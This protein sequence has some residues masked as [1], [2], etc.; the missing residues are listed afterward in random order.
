MPGLYLHEKVD[1]IYTRIQ[2]LYIQKLKTH[3]NKI[4]N[5]TRDYGN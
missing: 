5:V 3:N 1:Y 2:L 4:Y